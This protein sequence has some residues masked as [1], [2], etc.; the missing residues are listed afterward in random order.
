MIGR[1]LRRTALLCALA[2]LAGCGNNVHSDMPL[3][4]A[5]D[6]I[7]APV[8]KPGVWIGEDPDCKFDESRPAADWPKCADP[9]TIGPR[10]L[11]DSAL[12]MAVDRVVAGDPVILQLG[13][14]SGYSY[15]GMEVVSRDRRGRATAV[16][17]WPAL[18]GPPPA[19]GADGAPPQKVTQHPL[20]GLEIRGDDCFAVDKSAAKR[21]VEASKAW[22]ETLMSV[23]WIAEARP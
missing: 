1:T 4:S 19:V 23:H 20:P 17:F 15:A 5:A 2:A 21:S 11:K 22:A 3:F 9:V 14:K 16:R 13:D 18:C 10:G 6:E 12:E 8:L 7:G